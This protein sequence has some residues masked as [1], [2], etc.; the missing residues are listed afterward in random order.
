M[1][2]RHITVEYTNPEG[3]KYTKK[4]SDMTAVIVQHE[5]DHLDGILFIDKTMP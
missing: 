2:H 4:L 1:R 5:I 3:K